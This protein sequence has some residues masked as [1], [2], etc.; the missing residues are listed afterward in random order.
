MPRQQSLRSHHVHRVGHR[1]CLPG[2]RVAAAVAVPRRVCVAGVVCDWR[3]RPDARAGPA[4]RA[5]TGIFRRVDQSAR[6]DDPARLR[7]LRS[8]RGGGGNVFD[9]TARFEIPQTPCRAVA[10]AADSTAGNH[11]RRL[12]LA[13]LVLF[14]I[15][16]DAGGRLPRPE[17]DSYWPDPKVVW[18]I[19]MWLV[20]LAL[21]V[22][23]R[24]FRQ[25]SRRFATGVVGCVR[26]LAP[27]V[28]GHE[29]ALAPPSSMIIEVAKYK[30]DVREPDS[31][32]A[33]IASSLVICHLSLPP[34]EH[35]RHRPEPPFVACGT[36][37]TIRISGEKIPD[38]LK[39]LRESGI[40]GEAVILSTCN[41]VEIYAATALEPARA[42]AGFKNFL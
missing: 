39:S 21:L 13:G 25:S 42:F 1:C 23:R 6:G 35:R 29:P 9:A 11:H 15:G 40:A 33:A 10:D 16:L 30:C 31:R 22:W 26:I 20:Y 18:S 8:R 5:E 37:G 12:V 4:P 24:F 2:H 14:T 7:R 34:Y 41:R 32:P 27:H 17:G 28:L 3:V 19:F 38:A 36:A